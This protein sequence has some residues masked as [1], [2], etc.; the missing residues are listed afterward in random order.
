MKKA[1]RQEVPVHAVRKAVFSR[2]EAHQKSL[3]LE[4]G[5]FG[6]F[7]EEFYGARF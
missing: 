7:V 3:D 5:P 4:G 1:F 2:G 6:F